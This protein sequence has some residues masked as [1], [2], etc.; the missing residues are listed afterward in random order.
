MEISS[1]SVAIVTGASSGIGL[2]TALALARRG[3]RTAFLARSSSRLERASEEARAGGAPDA[4][5]IRCD[6]R[7]EDEVEGSIKAILERWGRVDILV[8][9]AGL[10]LNGPLE[11][12]ALSDW[13]TVIDTNLTGTF[14]MC[15]A[16]VPI[17][18]RQG[19]GQIINVA[20][21]AGRNGIAN[22]A[23]YCASKF[24]V[25]GLTEALGLELRNQNIRV[26]TI[27]PGSV[28]SAFSRTANRESQSGDRTAEIG[29]K[30]TPDEVAGVIISM[31]EQPVQAWTSEVTLR[32]L[33]MELRR[34]I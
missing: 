3:A 13:R 2:A 33:N 1:Q 5:S 28:A 16:V 21:G 10:S 31:L 7:N 11:G 29:Y 9:S 18:K 6:V 26:S 23:P 8:N 24:G 14:L 25:I 27:L 22:M 15:R 32:P 20:S 12:Y 34:T 4:V 30:M 17:M 19:S